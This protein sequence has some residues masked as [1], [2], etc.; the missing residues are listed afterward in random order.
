MAIKVV[1]G[2]VVQDF[3]WH[4][5]FNIEV[6]HKHQSS[7]PCL[8][9]LPQPILIG[10][11]GFHSKVNGTKRKGGGGSNQRCECIKAKDL[12]LD[13]LNVCGGRGGEGRECI[14]NQY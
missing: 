2:C 12:L 7:L 14:Q 3:S 4:G 8:L 10:L 9:R 1:L 11:S 13:L 6:I 5:R